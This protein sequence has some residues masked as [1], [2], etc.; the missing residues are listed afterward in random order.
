MTW[1]SGIRAVTV[2][3]GAGVRHR[4]RHLA[5]VVRA[6]VGAPDYERYL[7]HMREHHPEQEPLSLDAFARQKLNERYNTPGSRCC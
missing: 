4:A 3:V 6:V 5:R 1:A 7:L 2:R